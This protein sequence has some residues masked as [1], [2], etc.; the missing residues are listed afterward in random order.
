M[1]MNSEENGNE[2]RYNRKYMNKSSR[3]VIQM[4]SILMT[5]VMGV[6]Y[7]VTMIS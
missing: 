5:L 1:Y 7:V 2:N 6:I 4:G 3:S